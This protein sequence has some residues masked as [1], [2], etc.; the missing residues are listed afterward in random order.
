MKSL[1]AV[2]L[3]ASFPLPR[4]KKLELELEPDPAKRKFKCPDCGEET[5]SVGSVVGDRYCGTCAVLVTDP[6]LV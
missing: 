2:A 6:V 5:I 1:L 3:L 4:S